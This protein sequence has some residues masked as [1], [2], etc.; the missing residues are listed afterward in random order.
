MYL[1]GFRSPSPGKGSYGLP[2]AT[3]SPSG[4]PARY[5]IIPKVGPGQ[6]N[7]QGPLELHF[8]SG[9]LQRVL[10]EKNP[11]TLFFSPSVFKKFSGIGSVTDGKSA[12]FRIFPSNFSH[13]NVFTTPFCDFFHFQG[14]Q[15]SSGGSGGPEPPQP[16]G[17]KGAAAACLGR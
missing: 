1:L 12:K 3:P 13:Q 9:G 6:P 16:Q 14:P 7:R 8:L 17:L 2:R 5:I 4:R 10:P 15:R 11:K